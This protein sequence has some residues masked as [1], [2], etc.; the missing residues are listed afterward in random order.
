MG[1]YAVLVQKRVLTSYKVSHPQQAN[2]PSPR[3]DRDSTI[4]PINGKGEV[5]CESE[6]FSEPYHPSLAP[7]FC[8]GVGCILRH[9]MDG[10]PHLSD[11]AFCDNAVCPVS[12]ADVRRV[13]LGRVEGR[14]GSPALAVARIAGTWIQHLA[15]EHAA[16]PCSLAAGALLCFIRHGDC[17]SGV[18][19]RYRRPPDAFLRLKRPGPL[20]FLFFPLRLSF[21]NFLLEIPGIFAWNSKKFSEKPL[22]PYFVYP[23]CFCRKHGYKFC[24]TRRKFSRN[25]CFFEVKIAPVLR[26]YSKKSFTTVSVCCIIANN[27]TPRRQLSASAADAL[28][29][30]MR[31]QASFS[32]AV[33]P[34]PRQ[35]EPYGSAKN[36][37]TSTPLVF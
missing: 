31:R 33:F 10:G 26:W 13:R 29:S 24:P 15:F 3:T 36:K 27:L 20:I 35:E 5:S 14:P 6:S 21:Q 32:Q 1:W 2:R 18:D 23:A 8:V 17:L 37:R 30:H 9:R 25:P 28:F 11:L 16:R 22:R 4:R 12:C 19:C 34:L 7:A